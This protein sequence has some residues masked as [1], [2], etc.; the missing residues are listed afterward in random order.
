MK[1]R[2][3]NNHI[4][5]LA[6]LL[7]FGIFAV[8]MVAVLL[9]GAGAYKRLAA[10]DSDAFDARVCTEYVTTKVRSAQ[11]PSAVEVI[12]PEE[13]GTATLKVS[14]TVDGEEYATYVYLYQGWMT[15]LFAEES[16]KPDF[17]AG[18]KL[19]EVRS[20]DFSLENGVLLASVKTS[21]GEMRRLLLYVGGEES[22]A[23]SE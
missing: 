6:G 21:K 19:L 1:T 17:S 22:E 10:R 9:A 23:M 4:D 15:E 7:I 18:E 13:L 3:N 14:E 12:V 2:E 20:L 16:S 11:I 8:G 5:F